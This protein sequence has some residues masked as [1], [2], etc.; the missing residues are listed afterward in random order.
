MVC[1]LRIGYLLFFLLFDFGIARSQSHWQVGIELN[2]VGYTPEVTWY[3]NGKE[4]ERGFTGAG[5]SYKGGVTVYR[6]LRLYFWLQSGLLYSRRTY[7]GVEVIPAT[8][9]PEPETVRV[10]TR[11]RDIQL[12]LC[13]QFRYSKHH[14]G[15]VASPGILTGF[16]LRFA[17]F[18]E[19][20]AADIVTN[21][22]PFLPAYVSLDFAMGLY[23]QLN[24][25]VV[26]MF[27]AEAEHELQS[28]VRHD[29]LLRTASTTS[30]YPKLTLIRTLD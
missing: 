14:W 8:G 20:R 18:P 2:P 9:N 22:Q 24:R 5:F 4:V 6:E 30:F 27:Q 19:Q 17:R 26:F 10:N 11:T 21:R 25:G 7:E 23:Y 13:V 12:P 28:T 3:S 16:R 1:F 15:V 29:P